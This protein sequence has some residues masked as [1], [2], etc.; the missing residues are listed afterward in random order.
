VAQKMFSDLNHAD[1][2]AQCSSVIGATYHTLGDIEL[3]LRYLIEADEQLTKS[4][5]G[6]MFLGF[7]RYHLAEMYS[8]LG[9]YDLSLKY[10]EF[11]LHDAEKQNLQGL[12]GRSL[13]GIGV[14][15]QHQKKYTIAL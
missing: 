12:T 3:A 10:H 15:Y 9:K 8:A 11:V 13:N 6:P 14:V 7:C 4:G 5:A 1:G 2:I